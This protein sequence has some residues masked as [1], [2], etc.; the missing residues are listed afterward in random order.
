MEPTTKARRCGPR[1]RTTRRPKRARSTARDRRATQRIET[2]RSAAKT[3]RVV[4]IDRSADGGDNNPM[5]FETLRDEVPRG[6]PTREH[7]PARIRTGTALAGQRILSPL[8]L[9]I[10]PRGLGCAI[11]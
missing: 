6:A 5:P 3:R 11:D 4:T 7:G 1:E 8:R 9:P 10:P 2:I